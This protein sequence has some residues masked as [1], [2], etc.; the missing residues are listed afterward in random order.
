MRP[1]AT[2]Q[3]DGL[4]LAIASTGG[5]IATNLT[6]GSGNGEVHTLGGLNNA[7]AAN[8]LHKVGFNVRFATASPIKLAWSA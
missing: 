7:P 1:P 5:G 6:F 8:N 4:T 3:L 2:P